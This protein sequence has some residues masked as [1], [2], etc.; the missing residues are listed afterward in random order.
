MRLRWTPE[1]ADDLGDIS[2]YLIAN[3][4]SRAQSTVKRIYNEVL[5]L[6]QFPRMGREL[7]RSGVRALVI[8]MVPYLCVYRL[9]QD[10]VVLLH[11]FHTS[12]DREKEL[13]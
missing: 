3:W 6:R 13:H 9:E 12:Q 5:A 4:P 2:D 11:I 1:A 10:A 7:D 8:S